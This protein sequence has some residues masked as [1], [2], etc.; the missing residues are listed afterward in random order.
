MLRRYRLAAPAAVTVVS[1]SQKWARLP[2][3]S[4]TAMMASYPPD[5]GSSEIKSTLMVFQCSSGIRRGWSSPTGRR[6]WVLVRTHKSQ[7]VTYRPTYQHVRPPVV[8]G[9]KFQCLELASVP[10]YPG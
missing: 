6:R 7:W 4:T 1:I 8:A 10:C 9:D 2:T 3:E 5:S